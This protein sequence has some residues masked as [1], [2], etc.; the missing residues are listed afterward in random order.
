MPSWEIIVFL[1]SERI[2][3]GPTLLQALG[4]MVNER[5]SSLLCGL[6]C[7]FQTGVALGQPSA[8]RRDGNAGSVGLLTGSDLPLGPKF[9]PSGIPN[10]RLP[11]LC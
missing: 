9:S 11:A 5:K 7:F 8:A 1:Y 2:Y 3:Y 4:T 6:V 10:R